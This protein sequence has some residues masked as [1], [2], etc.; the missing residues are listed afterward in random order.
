MKKILIFFFL[1]SCVSPNSN[2]YSDNNKFNFNED[3]T[4]YEF[5]LLLKKYGE[6]SQ[7]PNINE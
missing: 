7:Y 6:I 2:F 1:T 5:N 3:L 4:F